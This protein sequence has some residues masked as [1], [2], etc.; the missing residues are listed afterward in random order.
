IPPV[1]TQRAELGRAVLVPPTVLLQR[2]PDRESWQRLKPQTRVSSND[3]LVSLPGYRSELRLDS[4][5]HLA[6]W[7][8]L[9]EFSRFPP[10]LESGVVLHGNRDVDLDFTLDRGRVVLSNHKGEGPARVR[11][12]FADEGW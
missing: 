12:R 5:V 7:G 9:P 3:Y 8:N 2:S 4:G 10:V 11:L 1:S 6:L